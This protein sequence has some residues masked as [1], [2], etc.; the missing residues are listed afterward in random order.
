VHSGLVE[1]RWRLRFLASNISTLCSA[2]CFSVHLIGR[3]AGARLGSYVFELS[4]SYY[5]LGLMYIGRSILVAVLCWPVTE[6]PVARLNIEGKGSVK[7]TEFEKALLWLALLAVAGS[8]IYLVFKA[9]I[10]P[11]LLID[12]ANTRLC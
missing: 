8:I 12:F 2:S 11:A 3:F 6:D 9:Y 7:L 5:T 10:N 1:C 4:G